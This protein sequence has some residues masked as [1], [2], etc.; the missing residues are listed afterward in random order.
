MTS[1]IKPVAC[2][3]L[4]EMHRR[5]G[6]TVEQRDGWL[7]ATKYPREPGNLGNAMID[8]AH[9]ATYEINGPDVSERLIEFCGADVS[10]RQIRS[11]NDWH[12][13]RL[14]PR[15]AV[16]FG[17]V[18]KTIPEAL[19]V[20]GG[21]VTLAVLGPESERLLSKVTALDL[22]LRTLPVGGCCQGPIF[23]VNTLFGRF[24]RRFE[25]HVCYDSAEFLWDVLLDAGE[26]FQLLS[27]GIDYASRHFV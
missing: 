17:N 14:T 16:I 9:R 19:D 22:R 4:V 25:L 21:W 13:Y 1:T 18:L 15:R 23:G 11:A 20:T 26:E 7:V 5:K 8:F 2:S 10:V 6:A 3:P 24:Q 12:A 27:A